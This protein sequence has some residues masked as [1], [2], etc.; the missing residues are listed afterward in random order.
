MRPKVEIHI[1]E[2]VLEGFLPEDRFRIGESLEKELSRLFQERGVPESLTAETQIDAIKSG[3]F[4]V[5]AGARAERIGR[6]VAGAVYGG[7]KR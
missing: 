4:E 1:D 2:L 6:Q 3:S 7:M 5:A